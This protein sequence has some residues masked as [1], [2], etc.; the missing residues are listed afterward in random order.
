MIGGSR[1]GRL[2]ILRSSG[3]IPFRQLYETFVRRVGHRPS[4]DSIR[5]V[6]SVCTEFRVRGRAWEWRPGPGS[7]RS[8]RRA[9]VLSR[10]G[11]DPRDESIDIARL[12][13]ATLQREGQIRA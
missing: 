6:L 9:L 7:S 5:S 12:A 8:L 1:Q 2:E 4:R 13:E 10:L 3:P 11:L